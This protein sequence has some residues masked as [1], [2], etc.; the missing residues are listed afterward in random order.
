MIAPTIGAMLILSA[1]SSGLSLDEHAA[2]TGIDQW[3]AGGHDAGS[4]DR[5]A[6]RAVTNVSD[7]EHEALVAAA[8]ALAQASEADR[9]GLAAEFMAI[10]NDLGWEPPEG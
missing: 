2:C 9:P 7:S 1:C 6:S 3:I 8:G 4:F 10:C 5:F